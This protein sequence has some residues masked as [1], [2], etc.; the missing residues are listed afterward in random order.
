MDFTLASP[1]LPSQY[2]GHHQDAQGWSGYRYDICLIR[3]ARHSC[4]AGKMHSNPFPS[5]SSHASKP[6]EL[7]HIDLHGPLPVATCE[8]YRYWVTFIDDASS[9]CAALQL[10]R[11]SDTFDAF[12]TYK[13]FAE[14][15][16]QAKIKELQDDKGGE[17]MSKAFIKFTDPNRME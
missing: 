3:E 12:K 1:L 13:A 9:H 8:G 15:Q 16:L 2:G 11:K 17:F 5:T 7:V 6:L 10:K 4:L 14:N